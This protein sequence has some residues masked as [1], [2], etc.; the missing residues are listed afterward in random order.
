M[1]FLSCARYAV[2][3]FVLGW[4][5]AHD[6]QLAQMFGLDSQRRWNAGIG[7]PWEWET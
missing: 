3:G 2:S 4:T 5:G 1:R 7:R 6:L